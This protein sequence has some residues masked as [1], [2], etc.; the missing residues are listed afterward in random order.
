[1]IVI[2]GKVS[3][4]YTVAIGCDPNGLS[5][6]ERLA[7][8]LS[9]KGYV[10]IDMSG[11]DN[12]YANTAFSV[13]NAVRQGTCDRGILICGTG[14]GM[15][16]A[17]NKVKGVYAALLSDCYSAERARKSNDAKIACFGASTIGYSL[18]EQLAQIFLENEFDPQSKSAP[19]VARIAR[20]ENELH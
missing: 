9:Q 2:E 14:I 11:D 6:K 18:M 20:Y 10:V 17:A 7:S 19:K 8:F 15:A 1:M 16:I 3:K 5:Y 4:M 12:I 13:A